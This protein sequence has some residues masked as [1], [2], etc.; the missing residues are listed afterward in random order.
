MKKLFPQATRLRVALASIL[1][2]AFLPVSS[3]WNVSEAK[4]PRHAPAYG[5]RR[6][7]TQ[8]RVYK[9][10]QRPTYRRTYQREDRRNDRWDDRRDDHRD[11]RQDYRRDND[12][13][14]RNR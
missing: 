3:I 11:S 10:Y 7:V 6:K 13:D 12:R 9:R 2:L 8:K 5:Y 1:M 14:R 4:P